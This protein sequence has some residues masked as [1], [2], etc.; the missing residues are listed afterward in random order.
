MG[1]SPVSEVLTLI[2][3]RTPRIV[4]TP[5]LI[6]VDW[7]E[8]EI[9]WPALTTFEDTGRSPITYYKLEYDDAV[10]GFVELTSSANPT[11]VAW[12]HTLAVPF[13]AHND[14]SQWKVYY[15]VTP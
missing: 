9:S 7:N 11:V 8:I 1:W 13:P 5:T 3:C 12:N 4:I 10:N 6:R 15:R 14:R 2:S